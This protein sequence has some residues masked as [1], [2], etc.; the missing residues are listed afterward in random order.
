MMP[1]FSIIMPV[2]N[3]A[4]YLDEALES[5]FLQ[6]NKDYELIIIN[7]GSTDESFNIIKSWLP[8]FKNKVIFINQ[9][10]RG[11]SEARNAGIKEA[12]GKYIY[13]FDSDD[14][15]HPQMLEILSKTIS[16]YSFDLI[17]FK[18]KTFKHGDYKDVAPVQYNLN[19]IKCYT[20]Q[21]YVQKEYRTGVWS[22]L[23]KKD[24]LNQ[25]GGEKSYLFY[26]SVIT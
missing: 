12:T 6:T 9:S 17:N 20:A 21:E 4:D 24:L 14:Y 13:F 10:N 25:M 22:Y 5:V 15:M 19:H 7:D 16:Q 11:L 26:S 2:Y 23:F 18:V 3:V 8:K 1:K